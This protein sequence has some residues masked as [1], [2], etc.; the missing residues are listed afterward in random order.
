MSPSCTLR[1]SRCTVPIAGGY[2]VVLSAWFPR[3]GLGVSSRQAAHARHDDVPAALAYMLLRI[4]RPWLASYVTS[5]F[6]LPSAYAP[7]PKSLLTRTGTWRG[8]VDP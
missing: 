1:V 2:E 8:E 5:L 3:T 4:L 7:Q 6:R